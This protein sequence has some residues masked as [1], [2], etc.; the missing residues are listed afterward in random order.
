MYFEFRSRMAPAIVRDSFSRYNAP[1]SSP[2]VVDETSVYSA[3][4]TADMKT[5]AADLTGTL[6]IGELAE[7]LS[8]T[9]LFISNDSG[10]VHVAVAMGVPVV[11]IF[12]RNDPGLS[13]KRWGPLG[14]KDIVLHKS[15]GCDPCLAHNCDK[16]FQCLSA[17]TVED[18]IAAADGIL[19]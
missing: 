14:E 19:K 9:K 5:R 8:R 18:V 3:A 11:V 2:T 6:L 12:G 4:V 17:I 16:Q 13:P 1:M 15:P 10:P 7:L